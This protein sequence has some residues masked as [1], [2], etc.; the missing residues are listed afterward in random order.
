MVRGTF[1][2]NCVAN[3]WYCNIYYLL[4]SLRVASI[5]VKNLVKYL[6]KHLSVLCHDAALIHHYFLAIAI[7]YG[8]WHRCTVHFICK[9]DK[10]KKIIY[11]FK[12]FTNVIILK[13]I[14]IYK[15]KCLC[16]MI[17]QQLE[18]TIFKICFLFF[19]SKQ[20]KILDLFEDKQ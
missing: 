5:L 13:T 10:H 20:K 12:K 3:M 2:F 17:F 6:I 4:F 8:I 16:F 18:L 15:K 7:R 11:S 1:Y 14:T 19:F 9:I